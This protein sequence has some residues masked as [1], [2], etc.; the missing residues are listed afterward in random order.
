MSGPAHEASRAPP[1][2]RAWIVAAWLLLLA[3]A[4]GQILRTNFTADLS[5]FLPASPDAQQRVL[6]EQ[7]ESGAP[8][9][10][11]LL[12]IEG[13]DARLRAE[14]SRAL[15][16]RLRASGLFEQ[17]GNGETEA[18][19][20]VGSWLVDNRYALSPAVEPQRFTAAG[21][22]DA[23]ADMLSLLGTPAGGAVK[24]LLERDPTGETLRIAEG[25]IPSGAP[26]SV[27]GVWASRTGERALLITGS[28]APGADLD[29]QAVT[30]ARV[31]S[32]FA[33][34][35][36][37]LKL[38]MSGAPL[39]GVDSRAQIEREIHWLAAAG[40]LLMSALLLA[41]FAS[42]RALLV[43]LLP[44]ASG[45]LAGIAA[46]SLAFGTV[47][48]ITLGFGTTLIGEAVD[49]AIYYLIQARAGGWRHWLREGWPTVRLGLLTSVCGFAALVFSGFPGLMQLGVFSVAGLFGAALFTRFVLPVLMPDGAAGT[50][51]AARRRALGGAVA[52]AFA[53]LP[54][55]RWPLLAL[56]VAAAAVLWQRGDLWRAELSALSPIPKAAQDLDASLRADLSAG[57]SRS[58]VVVSGADL[59]ATLRQ[60][61]AAG[62]LLDAL[63]ERG[64]IAGYDSVA[65]WLPSAATQDQ[66]RAS[67]PDAAT[68][69]AAVAAAT[70]GGP[71]RAERLAPFMAEVQA[72]RQRPPV[73]LAGL[74]GAGLSPLIDA[75][76][77]QRKDGSWVTLL[78]LQPPQAASAGLDTAAVRASLQALPGSQVIE[79]GA[80]L[81]RLYAR[82]LRE[83]QVQ[84][85]FGALGVVLLMAFTLRSP[86]R[87]LAVC[88]PLLLAVLLTLGGLAALQVQ[89]GIL[90][91]VGLLLVVAVGSNYALFFDL[92]RRRLPADDD[93][94][95]LA[96]LLLANLTTVL[97]FGLLALSAIPA[98]SAIGR[99][100]A[101]GALLALLL[102]AAFAPRMFGAKPA[103]Q[104]A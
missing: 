24:P 104:G 65:R 16:A 44:V 72:A 17:V 63:V 15:A 57:D 61:E 19:A 101:P 39:F 54:R 53:W 99:V 77:L 20:Q 41:A 36:G 51:G 18:W 38:L 33:A 7:L 70:A 31:R 14:A 73:T 1:R 43:A 40:T 78:P 49:Y 4:L 84:A 9:R 23:F 82:Y 64:A 91:L 74:R 46:V 50:R 95:T 79:I 85:L 93:A 94:D 28:K 88:Q 102:A 96:S 55:L 89:L 87:L 13:G 68:L 35:G 25:L 47:H 67:L 30:I 75:L 66:R 5:A 100:V 97:S 71:L 90:H 12:A 48:G 69:H 11:L 8:A 2:H 6:I 27:E 34:V 42:L 98:L 92:L 58:L 10:T 26:R 52:R 21:L 81:S 103:S 45:V 80:E 83:A 37:D 86:A 32:E 59:E 22:R 76:L 3:A 29:A 56:G 62:R 60:A